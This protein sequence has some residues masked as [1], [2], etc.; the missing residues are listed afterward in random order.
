M[1]TKFEQRREWVMVQFKNQ[2]SGTSMS[3]KAKKKLLKTLW[4]EAKRKYK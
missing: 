4:K 2:V 3:N 1:K